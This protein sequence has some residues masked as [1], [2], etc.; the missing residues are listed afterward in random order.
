MASLVCTTTTFGPSAAKARSSAA[1]T[2]STATAS[3]GTPK[4]S[5][6]PTK[7]GRASSVAVAWP[8][9]PSMYSRR[10]P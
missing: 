8:K 4:D 2:S 1:R 10:M 7:S 6:R 9:A 3:A 5:A